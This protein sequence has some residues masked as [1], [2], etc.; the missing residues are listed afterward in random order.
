MEHK[1]R[2][3]LFTALLSVMFSL[4]CARQS[5]TSSTPQ[6]PA[7][8]TPPKME[9]QSANWKIRVS[10]VKRVAKEP[11]R[12]DPVLDPIK[13]NEGP[14]NK[15]DTVRAWLDIEYLGQSGELPPPAI[16]L[17]DGSGKNIAALKAAVNAG[18]GFEIPEPTEPDYDK[19]FKAIQEV[20][21]WVNPD[22]KDNKPR[23]FKAGDKIYVEYYFRDPN[24]DSELRL[25]FNDVSPISLGRPVKKQ[26]N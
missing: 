19:R 14:E 16:Q 24:D 11:L 21:Y 1:N 23:L 15:F 3:A 7:A 20:L 10:D 12:Y 6:A 4:S 5:G 18:P 8:A 17:I 2:V 9:A 13:P 26:G 22:D 25:V